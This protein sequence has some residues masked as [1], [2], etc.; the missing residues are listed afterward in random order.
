[1]FSADIRRFVGTDQNVPDRS[2]LLTKLN[3]IGAALNSHKGHLGMGK[4]LLKEE[5]G[6]DMQSSD[7]RA[8]GYC[9]HG[10]SEG[11]EF[12]RLAVRSS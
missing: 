2:C 10:C 9:P 8:P 3:Y 11:W 1:M 12:S 4:P 6:Q 7:R 5:I